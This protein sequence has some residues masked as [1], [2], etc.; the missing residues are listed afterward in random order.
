[1]RWDL[2]FAIKL[3]FIAKLQSR[4]KS[5]YN[6]HPK[7]DVAC[8][9][10][11]ISGL[12]ADVQA[13][14]EELSR[15]RDSTAASAVMGSPRALSRRG[16]RLR[17]VIALPQ[18][19]TIPSSLLE[20][21]GSSV[22]TVEPSELIQLASQSLQGVRPSQQQQHVSSLRG[23]AAGLS[24]SPSGLISRSPCSTFEATDD[25]VERSASPPPPDPSAKELNVYYG[26]GEQE[27]NN[28]GGLIV[29]A[30]LHKAGTSPSSAAAGS[31][32]HHLSAYGG[33]G[34]LGGGP[35]PSASRR[36]GMEGPSSIHSL[37]ADDRAM[38]ILDTLLT[39]R[40][41]RGDQ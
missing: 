25:G 37:A 12:E 34:S 21:S 16:S 38:K 41:V 3:T 23:T 6:F 19:S 10:D 35:L 7:A 13:L 4:T 40:K 39:G 33:G 22:D 26:S 1:M 29:Q 24:R 31:R 8:L 20:A 27:R 2:A 15:A 9:E 18:Q 5:Q 32:H 11:V 30:V 28:A 17:T 36:L 14:R